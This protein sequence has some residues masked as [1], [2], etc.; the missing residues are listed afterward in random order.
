MYIDRSGDSGEELPLCQGGDGRTGPC[1]V[2]LSDSNHGST[3]HLRTD[4]LDGHTGENC[5]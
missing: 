2:A 4:E 1:S 5:S 3:G